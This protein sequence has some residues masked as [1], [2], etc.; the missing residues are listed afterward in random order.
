MQDANHP[1]LF[2]LGSIL[3]CLVLSAG[4]QAQNYRSKRG[5]V[6]RASQARI[7]HK[8]GA[9]FVDVRSRSSYRKQHIA[10]AVHTTWQHF[11]QS[12]SPQRGCLLRKR[13]LLRKRLRALGVS[14]NNHVVVY[15]APTRGWG[16]EGRITWMLRTFG[17]QKTVLVDGGFFAL[18]QAGLPLS[19]IVPTPKTGDITIRRTT[20]WSIHGSTLRKRRRGPKRLR[21]IVVDT[22]ELREFKGKTPYGEHRGG[23][24][25]GAV[26]LYFKVLL[27]KRGFLK[28]RR[29]ILQILKRK[30][31]VSKRPIVLYCTGGIRSAW[32]TVILF[33][34]GFHNVKNYAGSMWEWS[35]RPAK[36]YP[37][38][39]AN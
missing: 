16:E 30:A 38:T 10:G 18:T 9:L 35:A 39:T 17:H 25:P 8:K 11:S 20:R 14:Q 19:K 21:P 32:L 4:A 2:F 22:R 36:K 28:S 12:K 34:L 31:I 7:L 1:W 5:W 29:E 3:S 33:D 15:G 23:H 13:S 24:I 26:H 27:N 6:I 37:L